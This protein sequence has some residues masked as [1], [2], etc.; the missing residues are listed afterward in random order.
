[1]KI[2]QYFIIILCNY[3]L[4]QL[5]LQDYYYYYTIIRSVTYLDPTAFPST[6]VIV[7]TTTT[8][9]YLSLSATTAFTTV[10]S[11][12]VVLPS[13][14]LGV[15]FVVVG[16]AAL[17]LRT[18]SNNNNNNNNNNKK[19]SSS[20]AALLLLNPINNALPWEVLDLLMRGFSLTVVLINAAIDYDITSF[21]F[22]LLSRLW[23]VLLW[24]IFAVALNQQPEEEEEEGDS[25]ENKN[26]LQRRATLFHSHH[27]HHNNNNLSKLI[28]YE[29]FLCSKFRVIVFSMVAVC[30]LLDLSILRLL[31]WLPTEFSKYVGGYPNLFVLRCCVYGSNVSLVLQGIASTTTIVY[32]SSSNIVLSTLSVVLVISLMLKTSMDTVVALQKERSDKM[33]AVLELDQQHLLRSMEMVVGVVVKDTTIMGSSG[34]STVVVADGNGRCGRYTP[35]EGRAL[36]D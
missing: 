13:S 20:S 12:W 36:L 31:P 26:W 24:T 28:N 27:H 2:L 23:I 6:T 8:S 4:S 21:I 25:S 5:L 35:E 14:I 16:I 7:Y 15:L 10:S 1:M 11:V 9:P 3:F 34:S 22:F 17:L 33:V 32:Q 18:T 30:G 19:K 29:V